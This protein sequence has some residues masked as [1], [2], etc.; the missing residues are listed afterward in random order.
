MK[1]EIKSFYL[2]MPGAL[3]ARVFFLTAIAG[4][5]ILCAQTPPPADAQAQDQQARQML[6]LMTTIN[7]TNQAALAVSNTIPMPRF[8]NWPVPPSRE[9]LPNVSATATQPAISKPVMPAAVRDK[10]LYSFQA[11]NLEMK[12]ALA[13][14]ARGNRLNIVPDQDVIGQV[15]L[16]VFDLPLEKFMQALLEGHDL[17]WSD[18]GELIR[19]RSIETRMYSIDYLRLNRKGMS[20]SSA[21]LSSSSTGGAGGQSGG[22][23]G[24][25]GGGGGGAGGGGAGGAGGAGGTVGGSSINLTQDNPVDFWKEMKEEIAQ[26]LTPAGKASLAINM[27]AGVIN[28]T[29]RPSALKRVE[30]YLG[31][32]SGTV[33]RQVDIEAKLYDVMLNDNFAFGIDWAKVVDTASSGVL[34][35]VGLPYGGLPGTTPSITPGGDFKLRPASLVM[36]FT[37]K[38]AAVALTALQEQGNVSVISQPRLRTLNNQTAMIKVG[39]DTPFFSQNVYYQPYYVGGGGVNNPSSSADNTIVQSTYTTITIGTILSLTPQISTNG[40]ISMDISPVIT[41]LVGTETSNDKNTTAPILDIKQVSTLVSVNDGDTIIIGGLI[42]S[43]T[44]KSVRK[45]PVLGDLPL[46]GKLF[47]GKFDAK[48]KTELVIFL[49]PSIVR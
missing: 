17:A 34:R 21:T 49:T 15:T 7:P 32:V 20:T 27:T 44:A 11:E 42:Q 45:I 6:Q 40:S 2:P 10:K 8:D 3:S 31:Q 18:D 41:T 16:D 13:L 26:L 39:T 28:I 47:T 5:S 24:A 43:K 37:N 29:D 23:G 9:G 22:G 19:V 46:V 30:N 25:S 1:P 12:S 33:H 14:F 35:S 38:N 36:V 48:K 4:A